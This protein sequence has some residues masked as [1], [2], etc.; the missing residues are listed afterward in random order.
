MGGSSYSTLGWEVPLH[1]YNYGRFH[2]IEMKMGGYG[3]AV[4]R[5]LRPTY[6]WEVPLRATYRWEVPLRATYRWEVPNLI[7]S[8]EYTLLTDG[9]FHYRPF[10]DGRFHYRPFIDGRFRIA[11][12]EMCCSES[13]PL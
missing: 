11:G 3:F 6:R 9:R 4:K 5:S 13:S 1:R 7:R 2:Y 10:T 8:R 12:L